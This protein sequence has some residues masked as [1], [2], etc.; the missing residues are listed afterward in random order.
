MVFGAIASAE[1]ASSPDTKLSVDA[2]VQTPVGDI[3]LENNY[4]DD[5]ASKRLFD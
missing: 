1:A 4:F 3:K 2:T 5:A